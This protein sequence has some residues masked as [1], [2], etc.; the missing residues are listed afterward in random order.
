MIPIW[1]AL[2][3]IGMGAGFGLMFPMRARYFGRKAFGSIGGFSSLFMTPI[4]VA[5]PIYLGWVYDTTGSYITAFTLV[6]ALLALSGVL[7]S[8]ILPPRP[9][10]VVTDIRKIM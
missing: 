8:L 7:M 6:A 10:A 9:P 4:G 1:F 3:G 2:Y 5:T